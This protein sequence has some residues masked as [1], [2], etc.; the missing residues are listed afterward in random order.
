ME[1]YVRNSLQ[2]CQGKGKFKR[3]LNSGRPVFSEDIDDGLFTFLQE[4]RAAGRVVSNRLL[5]E[6]ARKLA[7]EAKLGNFNASS[8]YLSRWK[9]RINVS[10][11]AAHNDS[12]KLP[13][14]H[15]EAVSAFR[16]TVGTRRLQHDYS[17]FSIGNMDQT[18]VRMYQPA[19]Q[20]N[21]VAG[22]ASIGIANTGCSRRGCTVALCATAA[23]IKLPAFIILK[24][25]TGRVP[26]KVLFALN[27]PGMI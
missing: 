10:L 25:P 26:P 11:C 8:Q 1:L 24:E 16:R 6:Q 13:I 20:T 5:Q 27:V 2:E 14:N 15:A 22:E 19:S 23:G 18:M 7:S 17:D 12:Q 4:E 3:S 21:N 9:K